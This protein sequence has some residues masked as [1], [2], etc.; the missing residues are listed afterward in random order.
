[1]YFNCLRGSVGSGFCSYGQCHNTCGK[2]KALLIEDFFLVKGGESSQNPDR[3]DE[4]DRLQTIA[5]M[6]MPRI[7]AMASDWSA[8]RETVRFFSRSRREKG[9]HSPRRN[10]DEKPCGV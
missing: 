6:A 3:S 2:K 4:P 7:E 9:R 10:R 8:N 5:T 1:M